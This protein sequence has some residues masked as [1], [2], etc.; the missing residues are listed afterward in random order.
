[1]AVAE[2]IRPGLLQTIELP[3]DVECSLGP[4]RG[5][6]VVDRRPPELRARTP[7]EEPEQAVAVAVNTD[8]EELRAFIL[9]RLSRSPREERQEMAAA[10][11]WSEPQPD[12]CSG[13]LG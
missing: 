3:V 1:V 11:A 13:E 5:A 2:A 10:A 7:G 6:T 12:P 8:V 4:S 9:D